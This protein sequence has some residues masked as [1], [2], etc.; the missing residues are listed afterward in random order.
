MPLEVAV[1]GGGIG[2]LATALS[3]QRIGCSV[4]LFEKVGVLA[5]V[6]AAIS[7]WPNALAA[8][9]HL[10]LEDR[11]RS[12]GYFEE[13]GSIRSVD[14]SILASIDNTNVMVLRAH[15]QR[16]LAEALDEGTVTLGTRCTGVRS[17][18]SQATVQLANGVSVE[19]DLVVGADGIASTVRRGLLP[20]EG[21]ARYSGLTSCRGVLHAPGRVDGASLTV[22]EGRQFLLA[23]LPDGHVYW[24]PLIWLPEGALAAMRRPKDFLLQAFGDWCDPIP[25]VIEA[26]PEPAYLRT[27]VH[28]RPP[29]KWLHRDRVVLVGD[30]AHPMTPDLGQGACQAIEDAVVLAACFDAA[31]DDVGAA[32]A[33]FAARRLT[34]VRRVV[35]EAR[36]VGRL[37]AARGRL[38]DGVR[39]LSLRS[40]P[41]AYIDRRLSVINSRQALEDQVL[42]TPSRRR[43]V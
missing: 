4:R 40:V 39:A 43:R 25:Y 27:D 8:L 7:L 10:G 20:A 21:A 1:V 16:T 34:R 15:V 37:L 36:R 26:T 29:P 18:P 13:T 33:L 5:D 14:G 30:A 19:A 38:M 28:H 11:I 12:L 17:S 41:R 23:P 35:S 3:L 9:G 24:S 22:G 31:G 32:L 6:G 2:G 42:P